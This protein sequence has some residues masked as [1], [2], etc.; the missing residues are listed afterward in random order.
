MRLTEPFRDGVLWHKTTTV[1]VTMEILA[2]A[3]KRGVSDDDI[4]HACT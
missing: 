1:I 2:S 3:R 4:R